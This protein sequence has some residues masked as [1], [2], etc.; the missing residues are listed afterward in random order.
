MTAFD[1]R[2]G[3]LTLDQPAFDRLV[4]LARG[5]VAGDRPGAGLASL[6][7]VG[8]V[9][10]G[11]AHPALAPALAAVARPV[12]RLRV[13]FARGADA[14]R[15]ADAWVGAHA[16]ALL[17]DRPDGAR[18]LLTLHPS[19]LPA[20]IAR[21]VSLGPRPRLP[22]PPRLWRA[23]TTWTGRGG[24]EASRTVR[25][26]DAEDGL[27]LLEPGGRE[28]HTTPTA[29]WRLLIRL[30]PDTAELSPIRP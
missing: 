11:A 25:V 6:E 19:F 23:E 17:V 22:G 20:A 29:V 12:V 5:G 9:R 27:R 21:L 30:L 18:D 8:A 14:E 2:T 10:G 7:A 28:R 1:E 15:A 24:E 26:A 13:T 3:R 4:A 16:A